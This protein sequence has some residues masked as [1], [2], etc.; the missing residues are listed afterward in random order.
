[1]EKEEYEPFELQEEIDSTNT[2]KESSIN[3]HQNK[4]RKQEYVMQE[5]H[6]NIRRKISKTDIQTMKL[7]KT[8]D[9]DSTTRDVAS[10]PF[11]N[12]FTKEQSKKLLVTHKDE[13][14]HILAAEG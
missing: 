12:E 11:W 13:S 7:S 5:S 14:A 2:L 1:M 6:P 8:L 4:K 3:I 10:K 9:Q